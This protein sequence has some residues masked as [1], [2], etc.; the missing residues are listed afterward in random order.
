MR[1]A[2][3]QRPDE[4]A[5]RRRLRELAAQRPRFGYRRLA[6]LL[7][8]EGWSVNHK[9]VHRL[10]RLERLSLRR[11]AR[12][13]LRRETP[14]LVVAERVNQR[15]SMDF[16][17]D[18]TAAKRPFRAFALVDDYTR[19]CLAIE[20]D[21]SLTGERVKRVLDRVIADRGRPEAMLSD[22]GP[23]F[24][25]RVLEAWSLERKIRHDFIE[26]GKPQQNGFI[27]SFNG[28]LREECLNTHWFTSLD[29]ARGKL[30]AWRNDYN[31]ERPHSSLGY[32][33]PAEFAQRTALKEAA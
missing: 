31:H 17:H 21:T 14:P 32:L 23:E 24:T 4:E 19:E 27:E 6:A 7:R 8:R 26:P 13:R 29:D 16:I 28:R 22:N 9:R 30:E 33:T 2:P 15:W 12:K 5:L 11:K 18:S 3:R 1:Y 25:S 10:Y 20:V